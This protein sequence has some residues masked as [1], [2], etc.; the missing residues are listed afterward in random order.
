M[1]IFFYSSQVVHGWTTV[2]VSA[3]FRAAIPFQNYGERQRFQPVVHDDVTGGP[4][5]DLN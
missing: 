3:D 5:A 1:M 2:T 4:Q